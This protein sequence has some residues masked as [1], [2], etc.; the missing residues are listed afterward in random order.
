MQPPIRAVNKMNDSVKDGKSSMSRSATRRPITK[1]V[2]RKSSKRTDYTHTVYPRRDYTGRRNYYYTARK[3]KGLL[4]LL[5]SAHNE[6]LVLENT[7]RSAIDAGMEPR[8]IYVVDDASRDSTSKIAKK[9]LGAD[10]VLKVRHSGKGLAITKAAQHFNL[11]AHYRWIHIADADG[12]FAPNYFTVIRKNLRVEYAAATGYVRSLAG[13]VIGQYRVFEYTIGLDI[14]RRFQTMAQVVSIIPGPTS[15]FRADIFEKL[16]FD[17]KSLTEDFDVTLQIHRNKL[18]KIQYIPQAVAYTQDPK[19]FRDY[20]KQIT[21]WN[22]GILQG[23][24]S[25]KVGR[26]AQRIDAY[27]SWQIAQNLM[28]FINY[29]VWLPVLILKFGRSPAIIATMLLWDIST[30]G[31]LVAYSAYRSRRSDIIS[32]FPFIYLLRWVSIIVFLKCFVEVVL[33][34]RHRL[35]QGKWSTAGRRYKIGT[36]NA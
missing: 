36:Q 30:I 15:C 11:T 32:A 12:A 14:M 19:S 3:H 8:H 23:V 33:L 34:R 17:N 20:L 13:S 10:N 31:L 24:I 2:R 27:L 18:G 35:S 22:R 26:R 9:I 4:A 7:L 25:Y 1:S 5:I 29:L 28:F 6:E 16:N 21:R